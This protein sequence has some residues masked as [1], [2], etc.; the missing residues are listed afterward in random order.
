MILYITN[1]FNNF[2]SYLGYIGQNINQYQVM[3]YL[4]GLIV[5]ASAV[6]YIKRLLLM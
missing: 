2:T 3:T 1:F 5:I 6:D 4:I